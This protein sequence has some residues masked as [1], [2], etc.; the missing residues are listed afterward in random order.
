M[1]S[2]GSD[3]PEPLDELGRRENASGAIDGEF[4]PVVQENGA[5]D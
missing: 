1:G 3:I 5:F 4:Y 2:D